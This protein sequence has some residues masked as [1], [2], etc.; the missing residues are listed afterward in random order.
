MKNDSTIRRNSRKRGMNVSELI[1]KLN[2]EINEYL[3]SGSREDKACAEGLRMA[4]TYIQQETLKRKILTRNQKI[5]LDWLKEEHFVSYVKSVMSNLY[6][7]IN[8]TAIG[9]LENTRI[10]EMVNAYEKL[11]QG[12]FAQVIEVF[13]RWAQE[14]EEE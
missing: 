9:D 7:Y 10:Q 14:Q 5:V 4:R 3:E 8:M 12:E 1:E 13:S 11:S 6:F 2:K